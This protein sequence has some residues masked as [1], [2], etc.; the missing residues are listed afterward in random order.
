[1]PPFRRWSMAFALLATGLTV[2]GCVIGPRGGDGVLPRDP[3]Q[4]PPSA[5]GGDLQAKTTAAQ[6][7]A[8]SA[9]ESERGDR[10]SLKVPGGR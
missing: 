2:G 10:R 3:V 5:R 6:Q 8:G 9:S 4:P 1:M 7:S